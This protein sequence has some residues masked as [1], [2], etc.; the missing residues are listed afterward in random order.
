MAAKEFLAVKEGEPNAQALSKFLL[1]SCLFSSH[2]LE[3]VTWSDP[4]ARWR[5]QAPVL[6][7]GPPTSCGRECPY[8]ETWTS[9]GQ[10]PHSLPK[11]R[12]LTSSN[13]GFLPETDVLTDIFIFFHI[14]MEDWMLSLKSVQIIMF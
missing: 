8:N 12:T 2:G 5:E 11:C 1:V 13:H 7:G 14:F 4:N 3:Q 9:Q 6:M 10:L